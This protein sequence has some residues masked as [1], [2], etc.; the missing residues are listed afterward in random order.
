MKAHT[1]VGTSSLLTTEGTT[2]TN[3]VD[4]VSSKW[5]FMGVVLYYILLYSVSGI[6]NILSILVSR[7]NLSNRRKVAD[8]LLF[9]LSVTDLFCL[10]FSHS[11]SLVSTFSGRWLGNKVTC[12]IQYYFAWSCLKMSFFILI[13]MTFDRYL[14]LVKPIYFRTR[15]NIKRATI[16]LVCCFLFS[17]GSTL[18]TLIIERDSIK[19]PEGWFLCLNSWSSDNTYDFIAVAF[20]GTFFAIGLILLNICNIRIAFELFKLR[21]R[22]REFSASFAL[23][24]LR[25]KKA[26]TTNSDDFRQLSMTS[27][28][29]ES[30]TIKNVRISATMLVISILFVISWSPYQAY[31]ILKLSGL[32]LNQRIELLALRIVFANIAFNPLLYG[33]FN[34][35]YRKGYCYFLR[36]IF[37]YCLCGYITKPKD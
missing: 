5:E 11:F 2:S 15:W 12:I 3:T 32:D 24:S 29:P 33:L 35:R 30:Y 31:L 17:F 20:Y 16:Y 18:L 28:N 7:K 22:R 10:L 25:E 1:V 21:K 14:A 8:L 6:G 19:S 4:Q 26:K 36:I 23:A 34:R 13:L 37:F 9:Y 27:Q